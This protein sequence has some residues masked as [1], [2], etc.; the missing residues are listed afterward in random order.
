MSWRWALKVSLNGKTF[1]HEEKRHLSTHIESISNHALGFRITNSDP[2]GRYRIVKEVIGDPH[3]DCVLIQSRIEGDENYLSRLKLYVLLAPHLEVGG[4]NNNGRIE[5]VAGRKI[6]VAHKGRTWLALGATVRFLK[7]SCGYVGR[8]DGWT[9]LMDRQYQ[10]AIIA[11]L[12][13]PWGDMRGDD[14]IGGYH[15]VWTRDMC[16]SATGLLAAGNATTFRRSGN[17]FARPGSRWLRAALDERRVARGSR[18]PLNDDRAWNRV[19]GHQRFQG[20]KR[21]NPFH[22][23]LVA[24]GSVGRAGFSS[25]RYPR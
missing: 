15:L 22:L 9:D 17:D 11:S 3:Q 8:S 16:N 14:D 4:W 6:L 25:R 23:L 1:V 21:S 20:A 13:I 12:S 7:S 2:E 10:G 19:R 24:G 18:L 5:E